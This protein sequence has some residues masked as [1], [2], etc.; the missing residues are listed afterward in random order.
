M[1][2][3]KDIPQVTTLGGTGSDRN[4]ALEIQDNAV[5][6]IKLN[7]LKNF[8]GGAPGEVYQT[9]SGDEI[10]ENIAGAMAHCRFWY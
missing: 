9:N 6:T 8:Y 7:K 4:S 2:A 3:T 5:E 1:I 10:N